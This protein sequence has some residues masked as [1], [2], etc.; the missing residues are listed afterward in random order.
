M[1]GSAM[2][3]FRL[4]KQPVRRTRRCSGHR[5]I[6]Y[7]SRFSIQTHSLR[8]KKSRFFVAYALSIL[9]FPKIC[10]LKSA[11]RWRLLSGMAECEG[12]RSGT[13][14]FDA[15]GISQCLVSRSRIYTP[16]RLELNFSPFIP[17]GNYTGSNTYGIGWGGTPW[18]DYDN[19]NV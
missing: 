12:T 13:P 15:V 6:L 1:L 9:P 8:L 3:S 5:Y 4:V 2:F 10:S 17:S 18:Y 11:S 16:A 7:V 19:V 14:L